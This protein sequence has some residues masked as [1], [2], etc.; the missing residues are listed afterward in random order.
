MG[1]DEGIHLFCGEAFKGRALPSTRVCDSSP[2]LDG[3]HTLRQQVQ[4]EKILAGLAG[5]ISLEE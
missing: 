5:A 2:F 4:A 1:W 3:T